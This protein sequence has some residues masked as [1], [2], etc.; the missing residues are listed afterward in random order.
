V[1]TAGG[2]T[3]CGT[4]LETRRSASTR[5]VNDAQC[6]ELGRVLAAAEGRGRTVAAGDLNRTSSCA[7]AGMA[8]YTDANASQA[9]GIQHAYLS[10]DLRDARTTVLPMRRTDHDALLVSSPGDPVR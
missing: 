2:V 7:P 5:A 9:P 8:T 6:A 10:G 3:V 1:A 4:H